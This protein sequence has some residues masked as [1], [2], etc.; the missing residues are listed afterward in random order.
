MSER[1]RLVVLDELF[2]LSGPSGTDSTARDAQIGLIRRWLPSARYPLA[3]VLSTDSS[4]TVHHLLEQLRPANDSSSAMLIGEIKFNAVADTFITKVI[5]D[6]CAK[7]RL[8]FSGSDV[9]ALVSSANGDLRHALHS[10][11]TVALPATC[12]SL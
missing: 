6:V 8:D 1:R 5:R 4:N 11:H 7:E 2:P 10:L 12:A 9:A 3:L